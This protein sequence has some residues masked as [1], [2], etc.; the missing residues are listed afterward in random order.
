M[1]EEQCPFTFISKNQKGQNDRESFEH[2]ASVF[3]ELQLSKLGYYRK[4]LKRMTKCVFSTSDLTPSSHP[5]KLCCVIFLPLI[6]SPSHLSLTQWVYFT[7]FVDTL[8]LLPSNILLDPSKLFQT[9]GF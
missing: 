5:S 9:L 7:N 6:M 4:T 2:L 3:A 8:K 1:K